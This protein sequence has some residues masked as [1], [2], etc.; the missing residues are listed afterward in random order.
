MPVLDGERFDDNARP[1]EKHIALATSIWPDLTF[2][3]HGE[4]YEIGNADQAMICVMNELDVADGFGF[5]EE[6]GVTT[7]NVENRTLTPWG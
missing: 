2:N 7:P 5:P 4:F 1:A 3:D 6:D